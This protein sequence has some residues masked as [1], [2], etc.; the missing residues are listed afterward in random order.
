[1]KI[2]VTGSRGLIGTEMMRRLAE[3]GHRPVPFDIAHDPGTPGHGDIRDR[4]RLRQAMEGC[5]GVLSLAAVSRVIDGERNPELCWDVNV[6]GTGA[7]L[8]VALEQPADRR[9]WVIYASSR[10]VYGDAAALPVPEDAPLRPLNIY[11]R[12]KAAAEAAVGRA[13]EDGLATAIVRFSNVFGSTADHGNRVV[14]AFARAAATGGTISIEG[15]ENTFDFTHVDDIGRGLSLL[16]ECLEEGHRAL[17][18]IHYVG[19]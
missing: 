14:P 8:Q 11:G 7:V 15:A 5:D 4:D 19:G 3:A 9:P 2:L 6:N 10:E 13:R 12:S 17:P 16:I 1:M 18:P